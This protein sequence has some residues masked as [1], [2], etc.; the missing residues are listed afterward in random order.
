MGWL[1]ESRAVAR[2]CLEQIVTLIASDI[3]QIESKLPIS[4]LSTSMLPKPTFIRILLLVNVS[5]FH[6]RSIG[7][8][9]HDA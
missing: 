2:R 4:S 5:T 3:R 7:N 8:V 6:D 1:S 9:I